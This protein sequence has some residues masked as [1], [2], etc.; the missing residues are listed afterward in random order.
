MMS[1]PRVS[2]PS[3]ARPRDCSDVQEGGAHQSGVYSVFPTHDPAGFMVYCDMA[4]D[5]G[6]WT[7]RP[8]VSAPTSDVCYLQ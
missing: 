2:L 3:A 6:G 4:T 7:V 1:L 5:G 8:S